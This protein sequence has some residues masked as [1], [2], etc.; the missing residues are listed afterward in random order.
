MFRV[1]EARR[2]DVRRA[3]R[4][5]KAS[6]CSRPQMSRRP[7][8]ADALPTVR[9]RRRKRWHFSRSSKRRPSS[10]TSSRRRGSNGAPMSQTCSAASHVT[11]ASSST[12]RRATPRQMPAPSVVSPG[13]RRRTSSVADACQPAGSLADRRPRPLRAGRVLRVERPEDQRR[14]S[15]GSRSR[16]SCPSTTGSSRD[17]RPDRLLAIYHDLVSPAVK[18][19]D[20]IVNGTY[21][22]SNRWNPP[23]PS[24][25]RIVHLV[26]ENNSLGAAVSLAAEATV[27]RERNGVP[28]TSKEDLAGCS[29]WGIRFGT[30]TR[31]SLLSS[32]GQRGP[33]RRSRFRIRS[34]ST[35]IASS[36]PA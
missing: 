1:A 15:H 29:V 26:Q 8:N 11:S 9:R 21:Q 2:N 20:L 23:S 36:P 34:G 27:Q 12:R 32:T 35:S 7:S 14:R 33:G 28:V 13:R 24:R 5:S 16:P 25:G 19:E 18:P 10:A 3:R 17:A 30:A 22:A 31:R 6:C 4:S